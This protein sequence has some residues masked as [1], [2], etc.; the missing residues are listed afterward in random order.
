MGETEP[1]IFTYTSVDNSSKIII[2]ENDAS[3]FW[4][5]GKFSQF[6]WTYSD[7]AL[8]YCQQVFDADTAEEAVSHEAADPSEPS[9]GGCGIPDNNFPWSQ[10]IPQW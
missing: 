3:N 2:A 4:N 5:P 10:L 7:N 9:N 6:N 8:W 1:S